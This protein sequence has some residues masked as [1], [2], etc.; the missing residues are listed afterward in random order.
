MS[1]QVKL[2]GDSAYSLNEDVGGVAQQ[3]GGLGKLAYGLAKI[4]SYGLTKVSQYTPAED[5]TFQKADTFGRSNV[6]AY[7]RTPRKRKPFS[8][9]STG[10]KIIHNQFP[11]ASFIPGGG[12]HS[13][14]KALQTHQSGGGNIGFAK[15]TIGLSKSAQPSGDI[16]KPRTRSRSGPM[17]TSR[18]QFLKKSYQIGPNIG[19]K[20]LKIF[21]S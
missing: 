5:M 17:A 18:E 4:T 13:G 2:L 19:K 1:Q 20:L 6:L 8:F 14:H 7:K 16:A 3:K 9:K 11:N 21:R 12:G 10:M 15:G